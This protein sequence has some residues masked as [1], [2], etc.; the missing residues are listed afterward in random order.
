MAYCEDVLLF[1][2]G[3]KF[4]APPRATPDVYHLLRLARGGR[5]FDYGVFFRRSAYASLYAS[6]GPIDP[7][8]GAAAEWELCARL[9]R[10]YGVRRIG[11]HVRSV[12]AERGTKLGPADAADLAKACETFEQSFGAAGRVRCRIIDAVAR[13]RDGLR[14]SATTPRLF[15]PLAPHEAC[16]RPAAP[17]PPGKAPDAAPRPPVSP[18]TGRPPDRLLFSA[19]DTGGGDRAVHHVYYDSE[20]G[21]TACHPP[22]P[23]ERL[24]AMYAAR[25]ARGDAV[26]PPDPAYRS[27]YAGYRRGGVGGGALGELLQRLPT[28]YWWFRRPEFGD[29][30]ADE[31]LHALRGLLDTADDRV[32]LLNVGCFD[33]GTLERLKARTR[34]QLA[35][36]ETNARAAA[37]ARAKGFVVWEV[38]PQDAP[39]AL[40]VEES[41]D[42]VFLSDSLEHFQDPLR[43]VRRLRQLL[44]PGGLLVL[45]QPNLDS[46]HADLFGPTWGRWQ[47]PYHRVLMGRRGLHRMATLA[48][49]RVVRYRTRTL[50]YPTCVSVQLNRLGLGATVPDA[51]RFPNDVAS[52]GVRLTGWSRLLWDWRGRGDFMFAVLEAL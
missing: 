7:K 38:A 13:V 32:R 26:S 47:A 24:N 9:V 19:R 12:R 22:L 50:P 36:T 44:R 39:L 3:W 42:A 37:A 18:L 48:D 52:R 43:V 10:R 21:A 2:D 11:G 35:G 41:F 45:N 30:T 34:W 28:P 49:M 31:A 6:L 27:P 33:G 20:A 1:S 4:P 51:A 5:R 29:A 15:F 17:P 14:K 25:E 8:H 40:P 46:A 23:L 16:G